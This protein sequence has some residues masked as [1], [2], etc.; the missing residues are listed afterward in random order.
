MSF[1]EKEIFYKAGSVNKQYWKDLWNYRELFYFL[2]WR[3]ILVHYKQTA[4]GV[5]WAI[6]RPFLTM[7]VFTI[8]FENLAGLPSEK[9][10]PYPI[11]VFA[12]MLPWQLF[13]SSLTE[14]SNSLTNNV[15][16]IKKVYLPRLILPTSALVVALVDF[17]ISFIILGAIRRKH[18]HNYFLFS[19]LTYTN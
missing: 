9:G 17:L 4:I 19:D 15:N 11:M 12:A 18:A 13:A 5:A 3:D 7:I 1:I 8:I 14:S 10:V 2:A 6:L 16:L